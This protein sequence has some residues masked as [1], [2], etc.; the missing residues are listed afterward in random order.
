[1]S[2]ADRGAAPRETPGVRA[3]QKNPATACA[4]GDTPRCV[5]RST[6]RV[7]QGRGCSAADDRWRLVDQLVIRERLDHEDRKVPAARAMAREDAVSHV[8]APDAEALALAFFEVTAAHDRP[9]GVAGEDPAARVNL[10]V[11]IRHAREPG[12]PAEDL[13]ERLQLPRVHV[14]AVARDVP[15]VR[16]DEPRA[17]RRVVEHRLRGAGRV[18]LDAPGHQHREHPV[19]A[20]LMTSRS[21]VAPGM[22]VMRPLNASSL[23]TLRS[24]HTPTTS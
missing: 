21:F 16:E 19:T 9:S 22:T 17:R 12:E 7:G 5:T 20:A 18:V 23:P 6:R 3:C 11:E 8:R 24:R 10:V 14:L 1:M 2:C 15:P 13:H 4:G